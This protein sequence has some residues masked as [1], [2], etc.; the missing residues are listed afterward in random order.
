MKKWEESRLKPSKMNWIVAISW[1]S[2]IS[3]IITF[4]NYFFFSIHSEFSNVFFRFFIQEHIWVLYVITFDFCILFQKFTL[5]HQRYPTSLF[6]FIL[7]KDS[8]MR[9]FW[10]G[11]RSWNEVD[12][13]ST[14]RS[15]RFSSRSLYDL[16][17][18]HCR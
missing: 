3:Y 15:S 14:R 16:T 1:T 13:S 2:L 9:F 7:W 17:W 4:F 10:A 11:W 12:C 18:E 8:L 6:T 5:T